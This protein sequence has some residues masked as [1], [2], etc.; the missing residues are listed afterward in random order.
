[1][2][3][4]GLTRA[5][6]RDAPGTVTP[7]AVAAAALAGLGKGP[8]VV[9]GAFMRLSTA[10]IARLMP[11]RSAIDMMARATKRVLHTGSNLDGPP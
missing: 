5:S 9:P 10:L 4:P 7:D 6:K 8:R 1:V 11:R 2:S 3:T